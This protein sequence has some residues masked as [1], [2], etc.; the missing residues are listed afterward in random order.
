MIVVIH[1]LRN[2]T[3]L[4]QTASCHGCKNFF[5]RAIVGMKVFQPCPSKADCLL[6]DNSGQFVFHPWQFHSFPFLQHH[7]RLPQRAP[8]S[9]VALKRCRSCRFARCIERGM[10]PLAVVSAVAPDHNPVVQLVLKRRQRLRQ[11][12]EQDAVMVGVTDDEKTGK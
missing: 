1:L 12:E 2:W 4:L 11:S 9:S 8:W 6:A 7:S 10:N 5:R 3:A